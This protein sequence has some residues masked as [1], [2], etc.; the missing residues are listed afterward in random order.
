MYA[1]GLRNLHL[2]IRICS[3]QVTT[4]YVINFGKQLQIFIANIHVFWV[5]RK[6]S[7]NDISFKM[8]ISL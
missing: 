5:K 7:S 2:E 6:Q 4:N 1:L 3:E 8:A